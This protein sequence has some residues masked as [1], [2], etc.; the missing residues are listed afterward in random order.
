[1]SEEDRL[2][3]AGRRPE[4]VDAALR[5]KSLEDFINGCFVDTFLEH[6]LRSHLS[7]S[8]IFKATTVNEPS[9]GQLHPLET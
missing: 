7:R 1:M 9:L 2:I 8:F 3:S 5:P 6:G 4:D